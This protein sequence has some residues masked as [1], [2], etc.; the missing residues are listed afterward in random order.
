MFQRFKTLLG[1]TLTKVLVFL[2]FMIP[3]LCVY[4]LNMD[5]STRD[6]F[7]VYPVYFHIISIFFLYLIMKSYEYSGLFRRIGVKQSKVD[8]FNK[9]YSD[10]VGTVYFFIN[11]IIIPLIVIPLFAIYYNFIGDFDIISTT[12]I[13]LS[14]SLIISLL[15]FFFKKD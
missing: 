6:K 14:L 13:I 2:F 9:K 7:F 4:T 12:V 15:S 10:S 11:V 3:P 1:E 5:E 8:E